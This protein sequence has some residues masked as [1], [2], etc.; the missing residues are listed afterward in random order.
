MGLTQDVDVLRPE[1]MVG[2]RGVIRSS[3]GTRVRT[4]ARL[5][6]AR[7][8][9]WQPLVLGLPGRVEQVLTLCSQHWRKRALWP[10]GFH[11]WG[12]GI[13]AGRDIWN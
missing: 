4:E 11:L 7:A 6:G 8:R 12:L 3:R 1:D 13:L 2:V 9:Q 5:C 10:P